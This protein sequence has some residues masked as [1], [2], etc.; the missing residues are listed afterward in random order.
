MAGFTPTEGETYL[1]GKM[2]VNDLYEVILITN[3]VALDDTAVFA[4][5]SQP[6]NGG[7]AA[8][9]L[10]N[11]TVSAGQASH[12]TVTFTATGSAFT[13]DITGYAVKPVGVDTIVH[14]EFSGSS[15]TV[16]ENELYTV[17]LSNTLD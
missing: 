2:Y 13:G 3:T 14:I 6:S 5:L 16:A 9:T 7:Y 1:L 12:P 11:W 10:D 15:V 8:I 17:D 4:D